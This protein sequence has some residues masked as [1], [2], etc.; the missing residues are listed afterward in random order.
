MT[1]VLAR[2]A[3]VLACSSSILSVSGFLSFPNLQ[4]VP[5]AP[6]MKVLSQSGATKDASA[7]PLTNNAT[8]SQ[9][10]KNESIPI[11]QQVPQ[12]HNRLEEIHERNVKGEELTREFRV[13]LVCHEAL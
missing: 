11:R 9:S 3:F 13:F 6:S 5:K 7:V 1:F 12:L 2:I 4:N 8:S 10:N